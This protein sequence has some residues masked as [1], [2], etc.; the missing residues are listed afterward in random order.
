MK[1]I[2]MSDS[3]GKESILSDILNKHS[4]AKAFIHCGDIELDP[5]TYPEI[6]TVQGNN[7]LFLDYPQQLI[8]TFNNKRILITHGHQFLYSNRIQR[9]ANKAIELGCDIVCFGHTHVT[10]YEI[11]NG[12]HIINP[13][14]LWRSRDGKKPS[15]AILNI[16]EDK[17]HVEFVFLDS[18]SNKF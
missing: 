7:D 18:K 11:V 3:H 1:I 16:D 17:I 6:L 5:D 10:Q 2:V 13:G 9:I 14:S 4:D 8:E 15:Y 12:I